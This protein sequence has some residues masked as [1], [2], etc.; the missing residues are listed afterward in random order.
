MQRHIEAEFQSGRRAE[1][2]I[3]RQEERH[4][5]RMA[6]EMR[7]RR[8]EKQKGL[9]PSSSVVYEQRSSSEVLFL[10]LAIAKKA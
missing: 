6:E 2:Q 5:S 8:V 9:P 10:A 3:G 4:R 7:C 1:W